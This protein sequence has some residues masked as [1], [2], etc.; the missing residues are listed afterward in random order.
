[1]RATQVTVELI[2]GALMATTT[3][4]TMTEIAKAA[5]IVMAKRPVARPQ[6]PKK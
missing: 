3:T 1:M 2:V 6:E 4:V 5:K